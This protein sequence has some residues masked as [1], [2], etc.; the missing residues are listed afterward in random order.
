MHFNALAEPLF[1][2]AKFNAN[3]GA[4]LSYRIMRQK[5]AK[6]YHITPAQADELPFYDG[7]DLFGY[8]YG[9]NELERLS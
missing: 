2:A 8:E 6:E 4:G 9:V 1:L 7:A 5:L 3:I